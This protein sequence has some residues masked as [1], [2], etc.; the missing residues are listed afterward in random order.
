M[1]PKR[2]KLDLASLFALM[3]CV[4]ALLL[5]LTSSAGYAPNDD[6]YYHAGAARLYAE[7]GWLS[8]FPWLEFTS[9]GAHFPNLHLLQHLLLAPLAYWDAPEEVMPHA[10]VLLTTALVISIALVLRR[11]GVRGAPLFAA[12]GIFASPLALQ[13]GCFLK[14]GSTFFV[15]LV[16]Y[17]DA[18][19]RGRARQALAMSWLSVYA[20][21]GFPLLLAIA[22]VFLIVER[23][24]SGR[25]RP[26]LFVATL[27]GIAAGLVINPFWPH[28]WLQ[29]G[30]EL[31]SIAAQDSD[32]I[33]SGLRGIEWRGLRGRAILL[34]ALPHW[35]MWFVLLLRQTFST[36]RVSAQTAAGVAICLGL[37]AGGLLAGEKI[38][39]LSVLLSVL[40]IP[41]LAK[42]SGPWP[43]PALAL[44]LCAALGASA[45]AIYA[46]TR[47]S[48]AGARPVAREFRV[49]A[50][51]LRST[52][53]PGEMVVLPWDDFPGFFYFNT[54]NRYPAGLNTEF[55]RVSAPERFDAFRRLYEGRAEHPEHLVPTFFDDARCIVA[56]ATPR[57]RG[58][59]ALLERLAAN[60]R[61]SEVDSPS[62]YW[63]I[64]CLVER[65]AQGDPTRAPEL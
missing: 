19:Y 58:E 61:F 7:R 39:Y 55:L 48:H 57:T 16:W 40:F 34:M 37:F 56:R 1:T 43:K 6:G 13:Y 10:A 8:S 42:E 46:Y 32:L 65:S 3:A 21:V 2:A 36:R 53:D 12:L 51:F 31:Y 28:H 35:V 41:A 22:L 27:V 49:T 4:L 33:A 11:W 54:Y 20:Y 15:L 30:R 47:P 59:I 60:P 23:L 52:T 63:R 5:T 26:Q 29:I 25:S 9:L 17:V 45:E 64:F 44:S 24:W 62:R 38:L 18:L 50:E 14:G